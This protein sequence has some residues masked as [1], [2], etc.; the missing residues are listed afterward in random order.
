M[1]MLLTI[2][3]A[4]TMLHAEMHLQA[5]IFNNTVCALGVGEHIVESNYRQFVM[6]LIHN[7]ICFSSSGIM[8]QFGYYCII[9]HDFYAIEMLLAKMNPQV[10]DFDIRLYALRFKGCI[11]PVNR[12]IFS[13][14]LVHNFGYL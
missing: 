12:C 6:L 11:V 9:S 2:F 14:S 4:I 13:I 3:A 7:F 8:S 10:S 1:C 5:L